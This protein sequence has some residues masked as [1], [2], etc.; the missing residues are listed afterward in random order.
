MVTIDLLNYSNASF[1]NWH[2]LISSVV[3]FPSHHIMFHV[4][5][6]K[7]TK[8]PHEAVFSSFSY[9]LI[10]FL[11]VLYI[12]LLPSGC[13]QFSFSWHNVALITVFL[14]FRLLPLQPNM[15]CQ[16]KFV[17]I[18]NI[19]RQKCGHSAP[20]FTIFHWFS[21]LIMIGTSSVFA[22]LALFLCNFL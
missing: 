20:R 22:R 2:D 12:V 10:P 21:P 9:H 18:V 6:H 7:Q 13:V 17:A 11:K 3:D 19:V 16:A 1:V 8:P 5:F 4:F 14:N 15:W